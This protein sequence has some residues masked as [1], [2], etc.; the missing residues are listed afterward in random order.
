MKKSDFIID[1]HA[2]IL[3]GADHGSK[4]VK[5]SEEQ[6]FLLKSAGVKSVVATPHFYPQKDS[7][8]SFLERRSAAVGELSRIVSDVNPKVY[9]GAEVLVCPGIDHMQDF[10]RLCIEGTDVILLEMPFSSWNDSHIEAVS[11][12][13]RMGMT[14][15]M[16]HIDRY[17]TADIIRLCN[18][19]DVLY[20]INGE[21]QA[22]F[23]G[24]KKVK[25]I[26]ENLPV[27]AVGSDIHGA[28]KKAVKNLLS[29]VKRLEKAGLDVTSE[30]QYLL[31]NAISIQ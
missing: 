16:A 23:K 25:W 11:R 9:L 18:E 29:L 13:S 19:C 2:H 31:E 3:P 5:N 10:G 22:T 27:I 20:Q 15:V 14:V 21:T 8:D 7:V 26:I 17:P 12:I 30:T 28:D 1:F 24:R 6:L 4:S